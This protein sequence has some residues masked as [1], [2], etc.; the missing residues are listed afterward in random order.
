MLKSTYSQTTTR[1]TAAI[2][3]AV[4]TVPV[5]VAGVAATRAV[6]N[7][8]IVPVGRAIVE[9]A[10]AAAEIITASSSN[11]VGTIVTMG[12]IEAIGITTTITTAVEVVAVVVAGPTTTVEGVAKEATARNSMTC[13]QV[14]SCVRVRSFV[15]FEIV[16]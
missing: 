9:A 8:A 4:G 12:V 13:I 5:P 15:A 11:T 3:A 1:A 7:T 6:T 14:C 16:P 10:T 2:V